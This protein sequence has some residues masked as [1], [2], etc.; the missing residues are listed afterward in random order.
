[1]L[2]SFMATEKLVCAFVFTYANCLFS[3]AV[4]KLRDTKI[5]HKLQLVSHWHVNFSRLFCKFC[6]GLSHD[7]RASVPR[8]S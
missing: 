1:M 8:V 6:R 7:I 4:A 5:K 3:D 2:I